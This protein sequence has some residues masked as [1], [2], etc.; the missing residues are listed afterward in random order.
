M[1]INIFSS[2]VRNDTAE[3]YSN[4]FKTDMGIQ[5]ILTESQQNNRNFV[6][7]VD[8][9]DNIPIYASEQFL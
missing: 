7:A 1:Y 3:I 8:I 2:L 9:T 4:S 6:F 5:M